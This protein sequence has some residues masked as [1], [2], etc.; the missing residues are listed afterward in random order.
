[1]QQNVT[2]LK[3]NFKI[4]VCTRA[5]VARNSFALAHFRLHCAKKKTL[6]Q[7]KESVMITLNSWA[8]QE[9][10]CENCKVILFTIVTDVYSGAFR[11]ERMQIGRFNGNLK[12]VVLV[13]PWEGNSH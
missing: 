3:K 1:M 6:G 11:L 12:L 4:F 5:N 10:N 2:F 7:T 13:E 8:L 9:R